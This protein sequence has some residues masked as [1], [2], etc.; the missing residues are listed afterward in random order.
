M[1]AMSAL[2]GTRIGVEMT[3]P[4]VLIVQGERRMSENDPFYRDYLILKRELFSDTHFPEEWG[5]RWHRW[6]MENCNSIGQ[7]EW[8]KGKC[9]FYAKINLGIIVRE[10][11]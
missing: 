7:C 9:P 4:I 11:V 5:W 6:C 1:A 3:V 8:V 10:G 2:I